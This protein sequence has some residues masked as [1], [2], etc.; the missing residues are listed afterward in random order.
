MI[1]WKYVE[2]KKHQKAPCFFN[3]TVVTILRAMSVHLKLR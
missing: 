3:A 1:V 2:M